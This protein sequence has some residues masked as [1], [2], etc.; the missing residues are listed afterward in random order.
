MN[1]LALF[2]EPKPRV[3]TKPK[4]QP[5]SIVIKDDALIQ[6]AQAYEMGWYER[7]I[8]KGHEREIPT[9]STLPIRKGNK[10]IGH[11]TVYFPNY[12]DSRKRNTVVRNFSKKGGA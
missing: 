2:I 7:A 4:L 9:L 1:Q 12:P 10:V 6:R 5:I 8:R 11:Q 3:R